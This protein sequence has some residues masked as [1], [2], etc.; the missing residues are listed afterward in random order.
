MVGVAAEL[1]VDPGRLGLLEVVGLVVQQQGEKAVRRGEAGERKAAGVAPVVPADK[2]DAAGGSGAV[3]QEMDAG[4]AA[5]Q[6]APTA[7][8]MRRKTSS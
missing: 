1:E 3:F 4:L 8:R 5:K 2:A 6:P 7:C